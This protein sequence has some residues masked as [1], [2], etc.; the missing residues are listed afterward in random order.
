MD[1]QVEVIEALDCSGK[2][3]FQE[4][5]DSLDAVTAARV[6]VFVERVIQGNHSNVAP[7]GGGLSEIKMDFGPGHRVYFGT[8]GKYLM[9]LLG[10]SGKKGQSKA[11]ANAKRLWKEYLAADKMS[12]KSK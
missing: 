7:I 11:I 10:G 8:R 5:F 6:A 1:K 12:R 4:W 9:I 3:P 2:S